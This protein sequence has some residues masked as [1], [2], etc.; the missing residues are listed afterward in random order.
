MSFSDILSISRRIRQNWKKSS[1]MDWYSASNHLYLLHEF[2]VNR[3]K[4]AG[5]VLNTRRKMLT[6]ENS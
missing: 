6:R 1:V 3:K 4:P 5:A 2:S